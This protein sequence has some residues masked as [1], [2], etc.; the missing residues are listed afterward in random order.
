[1]KEWMKKKKGRI[2]ILDPHGEYAQGVDFENVLKEKNIIPNQTDIEASNLSTIVVNDVE[3]LTEVCNLPK[4]TKAKRDFIDNLLRKSNG[5]TEKFIE[6][7]EEK[8][9]VGS[10]DES[11][12]VD[13]EKYLKKDLDEIFYQ[14]LDSFSK[15][16]K[17][18]IDNEISDGRV[19][20]ATEK[21]RREKDIVV[22]MF[23]RLPASTRSK[24]KS[25]IVSNQLNEF[26]EQFKK[27]TKPIIEQE[28]VEQIKIAADEQVFKL[29]SHD[30]I[31]KVKRPGIYC[32]NLNCINDEQQRFELAA[33]ILKGAFE[34]AEHD[35]NEL[36][37][38]FT[39]LFVI[40][41]AQNF[42]PEHGS[43][44]NPAYKYMK[45]IASEGR[46]FGVGM[47]VV[48]Q[49][50][51]YVSKDILAQCNTQAIF[52]LIN[53]ND[54]GAVKEVVEGVSEQELK[55][56]PHYIKGQ[57]IFTGVAINEPVVVKVK[58]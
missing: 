48:T 16:A 13:W 42:A 9:F 14:Y 33:D 28:I 32:I 52:R 18:T 22:E 6:L 44:L 23:H 40:E 50:P 29:E 35:K 49:R 37:K 57:C 43:K 56:L 45:K 58:E 11:I 39:T 19:F 20:N 15:V 26:D 51:A 46:K 27:E 21:K 17:K 36:N 41:E 10:D 31:D 4:L 12:E 8:N 30:F 1:L 54:I 55:N 38:E 47:I 2:I 25:K 3:D 7:L 53:P 24:I 34:K 5:K